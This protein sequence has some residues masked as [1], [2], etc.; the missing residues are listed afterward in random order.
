M[1]GIR[2]DTGLL[3]RPG[4][5]LLDHA[6]FKD[7]PGLSGFCIKGAIPFLVFLPVLVVYGH[8]GIDIQAGAGYPRFDPWK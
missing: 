5:L 7:Y 4:Q 6:A 8:A 3:Q 2:Q 1:I